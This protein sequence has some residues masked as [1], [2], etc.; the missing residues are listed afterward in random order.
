MGWES[1]GEGVGEVSVVQ[2][3]EYRVQTNG[4]VRVH[5]RVPSLPPALGPHHRE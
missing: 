5:H 2:S 3:T 4:P 1:Q